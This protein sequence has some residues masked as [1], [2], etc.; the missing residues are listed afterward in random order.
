MSRRPRAAASSACDLDGVLW[1]GDEPIPGAADGVAALRAAG[2]RVGFVSNNSSLPV[3]DVVAKLGPLRRRRP[4]PTTCSRAPS[5]RPR[6]SASR[7]R[8]A[9]ACS[10]A[11]GPASSRRSTDAGSTPRPTSPGRR[12]RRRLPPRL[13]L[14][15]ARPR[16]R[17]AVRDGARFVATNLDATYP[18]AGRPDPGRGLDRRRG[19]DRVGRARPRSRASPSAPTVALVRHRLGAAGVMVGDRPSTDGALADALGWP[20]A[21]VLSGVTRGRAAG[22]RSDPDP[23]TSVRRRRPR[24]SSRRSSSPPSTADLRACAAR[25]YWPGSGR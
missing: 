12:R 11:P 16:R 24:R 15:R 2:L 23:A 5:P 19:G 18:I 6:C 21:L 7:C 3:G 13:R 10:C 1:R 25:R 14:R 4:T 22:R 9:R 8:P 17:D 20:F